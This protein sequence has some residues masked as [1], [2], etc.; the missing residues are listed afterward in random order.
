MMYLLDTHTFLWYIFDDPRLP[1]QIKD[2]I[3]DADSVYVSM[4]TLWE[5]SIKQSIKKLEFDSSISYLGDM[6]VAKDFRLLNFSI[7]QFDI[8]K[9]LPFFH[10]DPFDRI[11][12]AQAL[13]NG[14]T[15]ITKDENIAKYDVPVLA[16]S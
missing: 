8:M 7:P 2:I 1:S 9:S 6:C 12:I 11:L 10:N 3:S 4:A 15:L 16:F 13:C 5:I 14:L